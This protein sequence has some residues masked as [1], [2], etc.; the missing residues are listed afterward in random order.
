LWDEALTSIE[1]DRILLRPWKD[2]D[3]YAYARMCADP[4]FMR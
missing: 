3:L 4:K 1:T 2:E